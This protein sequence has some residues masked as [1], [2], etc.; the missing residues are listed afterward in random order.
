MKAGEY[1][2]GIAPYGYKKDTEIKNHL[3]ID[4]NVSYIVQEIFDMYA[5][6]GMSTIKIADELNNRNITPPGIYM[7]MPST[8][9]NLN[10]KN[11]DGRYLWLRTQIGSMLKN[12]V[13]IGNVVS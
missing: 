10:S 8:R 13:Y 12:Q 2:A 7:K 1:Q 5:N 3:V 4:E 6:K 9:K 11:P